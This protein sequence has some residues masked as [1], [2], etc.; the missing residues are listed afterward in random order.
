MSVKHKAIYQAIKLLDY[1]T[2]LRVVFVCL[3]IKS[4]NGLDEIVKRN[5]QDACAECEKETDDDFFLYSLFH[6]QVMRDCL[7]ARR[8]VLICKGS[9]CQAFA[10]CKEALSFFACRLETPVK[11]CSA[12]SLRDTSAALN[13]TRSTRRA[14]ALCCRSIDGLKPITH[15]VLVWYSSVQDICLV[16]CVACGLCQ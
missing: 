13:S 15:F 11:R 10:L 1:S 3:I 2:T 12:A 9:Q 5:K 14:C 6:I 16:A 8:I 4:H 7:V